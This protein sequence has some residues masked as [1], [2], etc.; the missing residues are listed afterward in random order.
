MSGYVLAFGPCCGCGQVFGFNPARVPSI[1]INGTREPVCRSCFERRQTFRE[2]N[3][4]A[5]EPLAHDA[6]DAAQEHE[7]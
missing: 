1:T 4:L 3:G 5:R 7:I 2:Q 6:Y